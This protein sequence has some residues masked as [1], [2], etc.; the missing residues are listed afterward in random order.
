MSRREAP[1]LRGSPR[2]A[3]PAPSGGQ[4]PPPVAPSLRQS[5]G[6]SACLR[7]AP[8][9]AGAPPQKAGGGSRPVGLPGAPSGRGLP[10]VISSPCIPSCAPAGPAA[11]R[12]PHRRAA[13]RQRRRRRWKATLER[14]AVALPAASAH[15]G[16]TPAPPRA[17]TA[18]HAGPSGP[19]RLLIACLAPP[20]RPLSGSGDAWL[21]WSLQVRTSS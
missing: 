3:L 14:K 18:V 8:A 9:R 1:P 5:A 2:H 4:R 10:A 20:G 13:A 7:E 11:V 21:I 15:T 6:R 16:T 19:P 17:P 12:A